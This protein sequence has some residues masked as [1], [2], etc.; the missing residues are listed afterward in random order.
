LET[1][2]PDHFLA[3]LVEKYIL[4]NL[5]GILTSWKKITNANPN[6]I[7][8]WI[9]GWKDILNPL[10]RISNIKFYM[11]SIESIKS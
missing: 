2:V 8:S 11:E 6:E 3:A 1:Y 4:F 9:E 10:M 7:N 5:K